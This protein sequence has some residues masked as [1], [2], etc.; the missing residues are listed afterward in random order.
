[1]S[2]YLVIFIVFVLACNVSTASHIVGG[3]ATYAYLGNVLSGGV[4][5][6]KYQVS[7]TIYEDCQNGQHS[8]IEADNPAYFAVY[9]TFRNL[10]NVDTDVNYTS[11]VLVPLNFNNACIDNPPTVCLLKK[12]FQKTYIFPPNASGYIVAYQRCCRNASVINIMDPSNIGATYYCRIPPVTVVGRNNS[13]IFKNYPPQI[14][15]INNPLYYDHSATDADGDS[16]TYAFCASLQGGDGNNIK[17][18]PGPPP[19]TPVTYLVPFSAQHPM[20]GAPPLSINPTT[21]LITGTPNSVGRFL[22]DVACMEWRNGVLINTVTRE[23]Q[24]VVT[25]CSKKV[26]ADIPLLSSS[27]N[28]YIVNCFDNV[29]SF[30]NTSLGGNTFHWDFGVPGSSNDT[31]DEFE[32]TYVYPDTGD[33]I[34][35]LYVNPNTTCMDSIWRY[36][37]V[38]PH[39]QANFVDTGKFCPASTIGFIDL[40]SSTFKPISFWA[41]NFG[42]GDTSGEEY[43]QHTYAGG[44]TYNVT[45]VTQNTKG[46]IDTI[47]KQVVVDNF[48]PYAGNDTIIVKGE[49]IQFNATGGIGYSWLPA[50]NLNRTDI[51][52]P[53]G[54]YPDTGTI[55]YIVTV[56]SPYGC[57]GNDTLKVQVVNQAAFFMPTAFSPNG[58][59]LNDLLHPVAIG[60]K[61]LSY[62]KIFNRWGE[63]VYSSNSFD[64]GWNGTYKGKQAELGTYFWEISFLDRN[65]NAGKL[66]GDVTLIR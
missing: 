41:W 44:G 48:H 32:P 51:Y 53:I 13:A 34:V 60:Y 24:F 22:V 38:Y 3:E 37:K 62:F 54:Y 28:T 14:I 12:T 56:T 31:S 29:V 59:G 4:V 66:K 10:I 33:F 17:P 5:C 45:L 15:C 49:S 46:C 18:I 7:I 9:D 58:D 47:I 35:H 55:N 30:V 65:G 57:T 19:Y 8:A 26:V 36:V 20:T 39:F 61:S 25:N 6:Q 2:R 21:G 40:T 42:D 16:L 27:Y 64:A 63:I 50:E 23:F 52:D 1:M 11:S 43:P